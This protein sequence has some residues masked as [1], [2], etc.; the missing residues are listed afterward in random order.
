MRYSKISLEERII[1]AKEYCNSSVSA[2]NICQKYGIKSPSLLRYWVKNYISSSQNNKKQLSSSSKKVE[3]ND[4]DNISLSQMKESKDTTVLQA[5][6]LELERALKWEK[7][8]SH[9]LETMIDIAEKQGMPVRKKF[10][11]KQ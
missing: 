7:M 6:I 11:A 8:R 9:A 2:I 1:I 3:F 5:R 4:D 10:G